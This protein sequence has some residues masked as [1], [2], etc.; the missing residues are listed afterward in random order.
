MDRK[1]ELDT[2]IK[3]LSA[4]Q[5]QYQKKKDYEPQNTDVDFPELIP[6]D[7]DLSKSLDQNIVVQQEPKIDIIVEKNNLFKDLWQKTT[8]LSFT[9]WLNCMFKKIK[10]AV[11]RKPGIS[12]L[13]LGA[14]ITIICFGIF[15]TGCSVFTSSDGAT[16]KALANLNRNYDSQ[17]IGSDRVNILLLGIDS[18]DG[19][20]NTRSDTIILLSLDP[21]TKQIS[22]LSIPR[23]TYVNIYGHGKNKINAANELGGPELTVKTVSALLNVQIDYYAITNFSGFIGIVDTLGGVDLDVEK[24][25][26]YRTYN[27]WIDLKKGFQHLNGDKSLQYVRFRHDALGDISRTQRQQKFIL[28]VSNQAFK[29]ENFFKLP[30]LIPQISSAIKTDLTISEMISLATVAKNLDFK[31]INTQTL[32]GNFINIKGI[33]YW[34][35]DEEKSKKIVENIFTGQ[36]SEVVVDTS[37]KPDFADAKK[38]TNKPQ[39]VNPVPIKKDSSIS[40][41]TY[42]KEINKASVVS[43]N[44]NE[45]NNNTNTSGIIDT[46]PVIPQG[47]VDNPTEQNKFEQVDPSLPPTNGLL[48]EQQLNDSGNIQNDVSQTVKNVVY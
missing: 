27:G 15:A 1:D 46:K 14:L 32:P 17:L 12:I 5:L 31:N 8:N 45:K 36:T 23:D 35:I 22:A 25:M 28:A 11:K 40:V 19:K 30:K 16:E 33:S 4:K 34:Y 41:K 48:P 3:E 42:P 6:V 47:S 37:L 9:R 10:L 24:D 18:P 7:F 44:Y 13:I 20:F 29:A 43:N 21:K 38:D 2:F 26:H 39:K